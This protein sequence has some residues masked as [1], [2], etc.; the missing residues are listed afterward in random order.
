[1]AGVI[2]TTLFSLVHN[3]FK[4]YLPN[5]KRSSPHTIRAY[6]ISLESLFDFVKSEKQIKLSDITFE[7]IDHKM[8]SAFLDWLETG[9][10]CSV[11]TR[12]HR[13]NCIRSFYAYAAKMEPTAVIHKVE[14][15]K[16][17]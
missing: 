6:Q 4:I 9:R 15:S 7:M 10:G 16:Y 17:R 3:F 8:I 2:D 11:S 5:Q 13:L 12:N 14:L 1:M